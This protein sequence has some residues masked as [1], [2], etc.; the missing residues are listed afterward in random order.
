[1]TASDNDDNSILNDDDIKMLDT[2][3]DEVEMSVKGKRKE[4]DSSIPADDKYNT[5][6]IPQNAT[7]NKQ[8]EL[9]HEN[10]EISHEITQH[11]T[12]NEKRPDTFIKVNIALELQSH[13]EEPERSNSCNK[14]CKCKCLKSKENR[15]KMQVIFSTIMAIIDV[16][17]DT[18]L[19]IRWFIAKEYFYAIY[20]TFWMLVANMFIISAIKEFKPK[21]ICIETFL[22]MIGFGIPLASIHSWSTITETETIEKLGIMY[23]YYD[24]R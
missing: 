15:E 24:P 1:M 16:G 9:N 13:L 17:T 18:N 2:I 8:H 21:Y 10:T 20:Q 22:T 3:L 6:I 12:N 7:S 19:V 14:C 5:T 11:E 23:F 4:D